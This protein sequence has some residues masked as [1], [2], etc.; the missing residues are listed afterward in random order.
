LALNRSPHPIPPFQYVISL[1]KRENIYIK[2]GLGQN[3][4]KKREIYT[5]IK[6]TKTAK[7]IYS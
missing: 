3:P 6:G 4:Q 5:E 7:E 2:G 1:K